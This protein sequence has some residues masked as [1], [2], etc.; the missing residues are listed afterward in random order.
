MVEDVASVV[1]EVFDEAER[2]DPEHAR[3]CL[4]LTIDAQDLLPWAEW[5][6][7]PPTLMWTSPGISRRFVGQGDFGP[8][9]MISASRSFRVATELRR[10]SHCFPE[11]AAIALA[12][13]GTLQGLTE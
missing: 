4:A 12:I 6:R 7:R 10:K 8:Y 5:G 1:S 2:R 13:Q 9:Q 11:N 3:P